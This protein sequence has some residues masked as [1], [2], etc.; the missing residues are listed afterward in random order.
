M[1]RNRLTGKQ[2]QQGR[3]KNYRTK[4]IIVLTCSPEY[5]APQVRRSS[6]VKQIFVSE[7]ESGGKKKK[8]HGF[9]IKSQNTKFNVDYIS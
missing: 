1:H 6:A 3:R 8:G 5:G 9:Q 7:D 4:I 2:K